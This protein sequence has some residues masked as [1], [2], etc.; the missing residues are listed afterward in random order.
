MMRGDRWRTVAVALG[1][2]RAQASLA[3][4]TAEEESIAAQAVER[5]LLALPDTARAG[6]RA[7]T[8]ALLVP[9]DLMA[10]G[11]V[12]SVGTDRRIAVVDRLVRL[13][14]PGTGE[15][16]RLTGGIAVAAVVESRGRLAAR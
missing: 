16:V 15:L 1:V 2:A 10:G 4:L 11:R 12:E 8:T 6:V 7:L 14:L 13:P 9:L 3:D 5:A